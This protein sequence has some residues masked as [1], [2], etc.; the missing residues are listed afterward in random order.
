M[1]NSDH[2]RITQGLQRTR[3]A[4]RDFVVTKLK[5]KFPGGDDW[6]TKGVRPYFDTEHLDSLAK[7][8]KK[9]MEALWGLVGVLPGISST[10]FPSA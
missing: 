10:H 5:E 1:I 4:V 3:I 7:K 2:A 9:P 8:M 6:W